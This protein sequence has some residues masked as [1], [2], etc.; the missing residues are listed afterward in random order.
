MSVIGADV[1]T[2]TQRTRRRRFDGQIQDTYEMSP[3]Q[4]STFLGTVTIGTTTQDGLILAEIDESERGGKAV[5][6]LTFVTEADYTLRYAGSITPIFEADTNATEI[7]IWQHPECSN[8][9]GWR[10]NEDPVIGGNVKDGNLQAFLVPAPTFTRVRTVTS[11][12]WS[13]A[14][15][16][17]KVGRRQTPTGMSGAT[18]NRWLK[19]A[20]VPVQD[21]DVVRIRETWQ[22]NP[23]GIWD[24]DVYP[25][26]SG[27]Y[28]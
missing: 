25:N 26:E 27:A 7:P 18:A 28:S 13:E 19:T 11:F 24:I 3:G 16:I 1:A 14:N 23:I 17:E 2:K 5:L 6:R 4:V 20:H 22:F 8:R 21:G 10:E 9:E 12:T 15:V